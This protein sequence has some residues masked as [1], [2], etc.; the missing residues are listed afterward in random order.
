MNK[1][2]RIVLISVILILSIIASLIYS[3]VYNDMHIVK[4]NITVSTN[5]DTEGIF[6]KH[7][8][9][10]RKLNKYYNYEFSLSKTS[11]II[12]SSDISLIDTNKNYSIEGYSPFVVCFKNSSNLN[13]YL[14]STTKSGFLVCNSSKKI[15]NNS[16]DD[17]SCD[18]LRI[19]NAVIEGKDWSDLG[20]EDKKIT[21]YCPQ[22]DT[23]DSELFYDFLL[24]TINDGKYPTDTI[25]EV[26]QKADTFLSSS[27][28]I[29]TDVASKISKLDDS[30][31]EYDVFCLFESDLL[32]VAKNSKNISVTY[33]LVTVSKHIY[34]Q[35][36][37]TELSKAFI[38]ES[39]LSPYTLPSLLYYT[40]YYRN[41]NHPDWETFNQNQNYGNR[42][43][44]NV[45]NGFNEYELFK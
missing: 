25:E 14:K 1:K 6:K 40:Y 41:T 27:N 24:I 15:H 8:D 13:N 22:E 29:R 26:K 32:S 35:C 5:K 10:I 36:S 18:F 42:I 33:P 45:K 16:S 44:L 19:I 37:N 38:Y 12:F 3:A 43:N 20:G 28:I 9:D 30:L 11:D 4:Q 7:F 39:S 23:I 34:L 21:I 31:D 17:I 2:L